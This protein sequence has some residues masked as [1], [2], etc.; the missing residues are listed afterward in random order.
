MALDICLG[1]VEV[2]DNFF[3]GFSC[4]SQWRCWCWHAHRMYVGLGT[5]S[6]WECVRNMHHTFS[7][8]FVSHLN[9]SSGFVWKSSEQNRVFWIFW[10]VMFRQWVF[11]LVGRN[12]EEAKTRVWSQSGKLLGARFGICSVFLGMLWNTVVLR[13]F[14]SACSAMFDS[15][16]SKKRSFGMSFR[17]HFGGRVDM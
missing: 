17:C 13:H 12:I 5:S 10:G 14:F 1:H 4:Q 16:G 8:V 2:N 11:D 7:H 15:K 3:A 6:V 9:I